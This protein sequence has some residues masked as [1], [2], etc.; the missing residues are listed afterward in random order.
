[1]RKKQLSWVLILS[2]LLLFAGSVNDPVSAT[3]NNPS[4][5]SE[6]QALMTDL[7]FINERFD[8]EGSMTRSELAGV[9][10]NF[11]S[12]DS[13]DYSASSVYRDVSE[14]N[15]YRGAINKCTSYGIFVGSA[16]K[17]FSPDRKATLE[18]TATALV[19]VLGYSAVTE[20]SEYNNVGR[21]LGL[22]RGTSADRSDNYNILK[23]IENS[24][25]MNPVEITSYDGRS[26][27]YR[28]ATDKTLLYEALHITVYKGQIR[29]IGE[30][31]LSLSDS[32]GVGYARIGEVVSQYAPKTEIEILRNLG[33]NGK[34]YFYDDG[35]EYMLRHLEILETKCTEID[36]S[37]YIGTKGTTLQYSVKDRD[38]TAQLN[39]YSYIVYNNRPVDAMPAIGTN[40]TI[41]LISSDNS[42]TY[43]VVIIKE[44]TDYVIDTYNADQKEILL[45]YSNEAIELD[46]MKSIIAY[47]ENDAPIE[48]NKLPSGSVVSVI[49]NPH[50]IE[51]AMSKKSVYGTAEIIRRNGKQYFKIGGVEYEAGA[52][53]NNLPIERVDID[54][55]SGT[56]LSASLNRFGK[57][58]AVEVTVTQLKYGYLISVE[59]SDKTVKAKIFNSIGQLEERTVKKNKDRIKVDD[60]YQDYAV[61]IRNNTNSGGFV[62]TLIGY[63]LNSDGEITNIEMPASEA[64]DGLYLSAVVSSDRRFRSGI[65]SFGSQA[66]L[67]ADA[68][69]FIVPEDA[70]DDSKYRVVSSTFFTADARYK[71]IEFYGYQKNELTSPLAVYKVNTNTSDL[72]NGAPMIVTDVSKTFNS[73]GE[74]LYVIEGIGTS[75]AEKITYV[76]ALNIEL[77]K[78]KYTATVSALPGEV[79][80]GVGDVVRG[81]YSRGDSYYYQIEL[82]YDASEKEWLPSSAGVIW[83][84]Y[85]AIRCG[86][87]GSVYNGYIKFIP[88]DG[89]DEKVY[90]C[91][92]KL[93]LVEDGRVTEASLS[94]IRPTSD[95]V[96]YDN[97]DRLRWVAVY[98]R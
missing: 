50:S 15:E 52:R 33:M 35:D 1:M 32:V 34:A 31:A 5:T 68:T 56:Q 74:W 13:V 88:K 19:R 87:A 23:M 84:D 89:S 9:L 14:D 79:E 3:A 30:N 43:D 65:N 76:G 80:I 57:V 20:P 96:F 95:L 81:R 22:Y 61:F 69:I 62:S 53:I 4:A 71:N 6:L 42:G 12:R 60:Y 24:L 77:G 40:G 59:Y 21:E 7:G 92:Q 85:D 63:R 66:I 70:S 8:M 55:Y 78:T 93:F 48:L 10:S 72:S 91:T 29:A 37:D 86:C 97:Y 49:V 54:R 75:S 44:F 51:I 98:Q 18:E 64:R 38:R 58:C 28:K 17:S 41:R 73:D 90:K 26:A 46:R 39:S 16:E 94:D 82:M 36:F 67:D 27:V 83:N 45:K 25:E 11:F 2:F 47:D